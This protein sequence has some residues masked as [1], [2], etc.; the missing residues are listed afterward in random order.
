MR[1]KK[2]LGLSLAA[3]LAAIL[4][5]RGQNP[6]PAPPLFGSPS[7]P[8]TLI[9]DPSETPGAQEAV[10]G[11]GVPGGES[12]AELTATEEGVAPA[13]PALGPTPLPSVGISITRFARLG[14]ASIMLLP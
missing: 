1:R 4:T 3:L 5:A 13:A 6:A 10:S 8:Y 9:Q 11:G 14:R 2:C 7:G 12:R